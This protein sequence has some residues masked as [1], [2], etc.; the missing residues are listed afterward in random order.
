MSQLHGLSRRKLPVPCRNGPHP[1]LGERI[2]AG[3]LESHAAASTPKPVHVLVLIAPRIYLLVRT[4]ATTSQG[5]P[6]GALKAGLLQGLFSLLHARA[7]GFHE[8]AWPS[9]VGDI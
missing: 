7:P 5:L 8:R 6:A 3:L 4:K 9:A 2:P 1:N